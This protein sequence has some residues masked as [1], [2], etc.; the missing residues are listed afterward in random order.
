MFKEKNEILLLLHVILTSIDYTV[1]LRKLRFSFCFFLLLLNNTGSFM[2][3]KYSK[4]IWKEV[5]DFAC[6]ACSHL[7]RAFTSLLSV[8][9]V[10]YNGRRP[11]CACPVHPL[12]ALG[13]YGLAQSRCLVFTT[14]QGMFTKSTKLPC[15]F[16]FSNL[17]KMRFFNSLYSTTPSFLFNLNFGPKMSILYPINI[18]R[19][20]TCSLC[21]VQMSL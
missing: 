20:D 9:L 11:V 19:G 18:T 17:V 8:S 6:P 10:S 2:G 12:R 14:L 15:D 7:G 3:Y 21:N 13:F 5:S 4:K 1:S 16:F